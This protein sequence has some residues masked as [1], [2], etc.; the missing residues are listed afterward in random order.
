MLFSFR[1][2]PSIVMLHYVSDDETHLPLQPWNISRSS[3][4]ILLDYLQ[5]EGYRTLVFEDLDQLEKAGDKSVIITF[6][7][8]SKSL[9]DFAIPELQRRNMKAIFYMPTA[10]LGGYNE[11][12]VEEGLPKIELMDEADII[13][14]SHVGMEIGSHAHN[15][16]MLE[17]EKNSEV[18]DQLVKSKSILEQIINKPV[19][20]VAYPYGSV[21][22]NAYK[23]AKDAGYIYGLAVFTPW[24][25]KYAIRRWIYDDTDN[26]ES[27]RH[28]MSPIYTWQRSLYDKWS[29]YN[30]KILRILYQYYTR[31]KKTLRLHVVSLFIVENVQYIVE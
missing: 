16:I 2:Y 10:H 26:I 4:T 20:S 12:S 3:Y 1:K 22:K 19:L 29:F 24:Q 18:I 23:L 17:E 28:K 13:K 30:K 9:W 25:T 5:Q 15:H 27:I 31:L 7:D 8:C 6:D 21:P 14:L 11:W